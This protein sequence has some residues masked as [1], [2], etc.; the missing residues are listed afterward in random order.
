MSERPLLPNAARTDR[1]ARVALVCLALA[2]LVACDRGTP[3]QAGQ[4]PP[5]PP[6][7]V[8]VVQVEPKEVTPVATFTGRIEAVDKVELRARV[9]GFLVQR[10]FEEGATVHEGDLLFVIDKAPY[11]ALVAQ[12]RA[13]LASA[14]ADKVNTALQYKRAKELVKSN[15]IPA[16]TVDQRRAEDEMAGARILGA[17]AALQ[18]AE[19]D[20]SYTDIKAPIT[21]RIGRAAYTVG[22]LV[23]PQSGTLAT[24][25]SQD[26]M[27]VT[28][29]VTQRQLL[30]VRRESKA[31]SVDPASLAVKIRL[32]DGST[33]E[34]TGKINFVDI[35][36]SPSTD[37]IAVRA[38]IPN[39]DGLLVD[40]QLITAVVA[41]AK[42]E[43]ALVIPQRAIQADQAGMF[44]LVVDPDNKV[45][46]R[47][48]VVGPSQEG[49]VPVREGLKAGEKVI[50]EGMQK[51][52][53]G[54][55]VAPST[56]PP[57]SPE[58]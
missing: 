32:A 47:R 3:E 27:Y 18:R 14:K 6:P 13:E 4:A 10:N 25:V 26:P 8:T 30:E 33:Y 44:V 20:L 42:P 5:A 50:V 16:A 38:S 37:T 39:P 52:R 36:V 1:P 31:G 23:N 46:V 55:V 11:E 9:E 17:E 34:H 35:E 58:G 21:G 15:A 29:P 54:Q 40:S 51:V 2:A 53:P 12:R 22:N 43:K 45:E 49:S 7:A 28:F 24:I 57:P 41:V 48:V 56:T 19:L